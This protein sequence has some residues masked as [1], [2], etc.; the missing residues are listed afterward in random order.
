ME[1]LVATDLFT[2]QVWMLAGFVTSYG[3]F[4]I[5][6]GSRQVDVAAGSVG[7]ACQC[8]R[9]VCLRRKR[10]RSGRCGD[11][12]SWWWRDGLWWTCGG[13]WHGAGRVLL[14]VLLQHV[15]GRAEP[16]HGLRR[17]SGRTDRLGP[18]LRGRSRL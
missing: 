13:L 9:V 4:F 10:G 11:W 12:C 3:L 14:L 1:V 7:G 5:H 18:C 2:T 8:E 6:L 17:F 15:V 16:L